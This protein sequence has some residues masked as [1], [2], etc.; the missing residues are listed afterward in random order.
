MTAHVPGV[1]CTSYQY[2]Y[3]PASSGITSETVTDMQRKYNALPT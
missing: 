1:S 3:D 2:D